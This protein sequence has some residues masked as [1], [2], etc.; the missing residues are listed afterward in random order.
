M[1][2]LITDRTSYIGS[3][4][5]VELLQAGHTVVVIDNL[6]NFKSSVIDRIAAITK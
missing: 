3:H 6:V 5:I 2:I 4:T 1:H